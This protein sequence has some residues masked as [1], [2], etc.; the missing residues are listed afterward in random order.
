MKPTVFAFDDGYGENKITNGSQSFVI[1]N[2]QTKYR[3]RP[4]NDFT[5]SEPN[6]LDFITAEINNEKYVIGKGA[7][8][9]DSSIEWIGGNNKHLDIG[10]PII[11]K[12]C[13]GMLAKEEKVIVDKLVM[14]LP[15]KEFRKKDRINQLEQLILNQ[16]H[17]VKLEYANGSKA[18]RKVIIKDLDV[19]MQPFGSLCDVVLDKNGEFIDY[20]TAMD[21]NVVVDIGARTLNILTAREMLEVPDLSTNTNHGMFYAYD[22]INEY[23]QY[24]EKPT[25][26]TGQLPTVA[27]KGRVGNI[28]ITEQV[29]MSYQMLANQI[30]QIIETMFVNHW[31]LVNR[32][33]FTGGGSVVLKKHLTKLFADKQT[34]FLS[35]ESNANGLYKYGIKKANKE[36]KAKNFTKVG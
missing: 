23:L 28:D 14:G 10:F 21:Y 32:V 8:E 1:P 26:P 20:N 22:M 6:P 9:I 4:I 29:A 7:E 30:H 15:V 3:P 25:I 33:I 11:L 19:K 16:D 35:Q 27:R 36:L 34:V 18:T 24:N 13:L 17:F 5:N 31:S 2:L 12:S